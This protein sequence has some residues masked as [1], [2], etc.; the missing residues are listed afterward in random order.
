MLKWQD[1][2]FVLGYRP[3]GERTSILDLFTKTH[4]RVWGAIPHSHGRKMRGMVEPGN[5][6]QVTWQARLSEHLGQFSHVELL[7]P[8]A[9]FIMASPHALLLMQLVLRLLSDTLPERFPYPALYEKLAVFWDEM[10]TT[11]WFAAY[12][13]FEIDVLGV[14]GFGL[15]LDTCAVTGAQEGLAYVSPKSGCAV[16]EEV[17]RPYKDKLLSYPR[18]LKISPHHPTQKEGKEALA[19]TEYFFKAH[20]EKLAQSPSWCESRIKLLQYLI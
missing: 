16:V 9:I 18:F 15:S 10:S 11:K 7:R 5:L 3:L 12:I 4:G 13:Q 2:G 8:T 1:E 17:G 20:F 19:L 6:L 14:L